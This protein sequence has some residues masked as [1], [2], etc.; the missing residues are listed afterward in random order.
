[1][2]ARPE[3]PSDGV[4]RP[5]DRVRLA[6]TGLVVQVEPSDE[7]PDGWLLLSGFAKTARDG[8]GVRAVRTEASCDVVISNVL[9]LDPVLGVRA[10]S[11]GVREGRI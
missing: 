8:I 7:P 4:L 3:P 6:D 11:I 5:G 9:V 10:A 2:S 1:M